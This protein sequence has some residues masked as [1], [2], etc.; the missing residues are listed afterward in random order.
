MASGAWCLV[1]GEHRSHPGCRLAVHV[2]DGGCGLIDSTNAQTHKTNTPYTYTTS[3]TLLL[4]HSDGLWL[5][6]RRCTANSI[7][8]PSYEKRALGDIQSIFRK[9]ISGKVCWTNNKIDC[10]AVT[11]YRVT[12]DDQLLGQGGPDTE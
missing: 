7:I 8:I 3:I 4:L 1:P 6:D 9:C 12:I 2:C 5:T 11:V 10:D